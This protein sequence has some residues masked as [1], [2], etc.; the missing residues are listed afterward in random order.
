[1]LYF[2]CYLPRVLQT[3]LTSWISLETS[4]GLPLGIQR[5]IITLPCG[6]QV[7][8]QL[9][10]VTART[11]R[12]NADSISILDFRNFQKHAAISLIEDLVTKACPWARSFIEDTQL[13]PV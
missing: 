4:F 13:R 6:A 11:S 3:Y 8:L 12:I 9:K 1:M 5:Y 10:S 7:C 2:C